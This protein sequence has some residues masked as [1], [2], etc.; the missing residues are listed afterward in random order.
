MPNQVDSKSLSRARYTRFADGYVTSETHAKGSD[1]DRLLAIAQP[2]PHWQALDIA[3][4]GGHTALKFAPHVAHVV[5]S[6]LTPRMLQKARQFIVVQQGV[7]NVSFKGADAENLPFDDEQFDLL[8]CR[9]APHHF[10]DAQRFL[11][12]CARVLKQGGMLILQ[13]QVLPDDAEAARYVDAFERLRDPSHNRAFNADEWQ[14]MC[15]RAGI[16]V[17]YSEQYVKRH[18][19]LPWVQRQGN[20]DSTIAALIQLMREAPLIAREWLDPQDWGSDSATF[21]NRHIL[22]RGRRI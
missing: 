19:F 10:P 2:Q 18:D 11:R 7:A 1:L 3:T 13:D 15:A 20:D 21:V 6:D 14:A 4:G 22:I 9:I 12:E 8:T 17:E 16:A 5:A